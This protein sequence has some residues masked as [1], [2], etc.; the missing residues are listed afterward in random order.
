MGRQEA[1]LWESL[2]EI[3]GWVPS[4]P[5]LSNGC[6]ASYTAGRLA[7]ADPTWKSGS[8][9]TDP[10]WHRGLNGQLAGKWL[11]RFHSGSK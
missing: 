9:F 10:G 2:A 8:K 1:W 3:L 7:L 5:V 4:I 11:Y 6:G